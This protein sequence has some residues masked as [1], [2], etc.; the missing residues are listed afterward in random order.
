MPQSH[1][2]EA[3][4]TAVEAGEEDAFAAAAEED[5]FAGLPDYGAPPAEAE[6]SAA[7]DPPAAAAFAPPP[8]PAFAAPPAAPAAPVAPAAPAAPAAPVATS[9]GL[10]PEE[11]A[12]LEEDDDL[13]GD[14][15]GEEHKGSDMALLALNC[16]SN[17]L[18]TLSCLPAMTNLPGR[19]LCPP[20]LQGWTRQTLQM[21]VRA[22]AAPACCQTL[23]CS[24]I[25]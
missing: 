4:A 6:L 15:L 3:E 21:R 18:D 8:P 7:V 19:R 12:L 13:M 9:S 11:E 10:T 14:D 25:M 22:A 23:C 17:T 24:A 1:G 5:A 20:A 16:S 2:Y